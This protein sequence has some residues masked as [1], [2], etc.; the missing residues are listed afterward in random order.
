MS[1]Y[2]RLCGRPSTARVP[3]A[4]LERALDGCDHR[5]CAASADVETLPAQGEAVRLGIVSVRGGIAAE[6]SK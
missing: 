3:R 1:A 6:V 4:L 5:Q 2:A